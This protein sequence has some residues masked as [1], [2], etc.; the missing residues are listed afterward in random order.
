MADQEI[1]DAVARAIAPMQ[2]DCLPEQIA[3]AALSALREHTGSPRTVDE[4]TRVLGD[5][6]R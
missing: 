1:I 2:R 4:I 3:I 6:V 5:G